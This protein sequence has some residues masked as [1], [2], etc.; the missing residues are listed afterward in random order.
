MTS[1]KS[2][3]HFRLFQ[4]QEGN[5]IAGTRCQTMRISLDVTPYNIPLDG[6]SLMFLT[7]T[8]LCLRWKTN[9]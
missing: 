8:C 1:G 6:G 3:Q 2:K 9:V 7:V 4:N 5:C